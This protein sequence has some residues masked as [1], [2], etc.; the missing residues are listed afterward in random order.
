M[1]YVVNIKQ[2]RGHRVLSRKDSHESVCMMIFNF[3]I[4]AL[5]IRII[6]FLSKVM[7]INGSI[8]SLSF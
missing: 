1:Q 4:S 7:P 5:V 2:S 3:C 8:R 6:S